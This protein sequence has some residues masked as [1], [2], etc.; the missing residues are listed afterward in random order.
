MRNCLQ[1]G[2]FSGKNPAVASHH[3]GLNAHLPHGPTS[4]G[5]CLFLTPFHT[6]LQSSLLQAIVAF[7]Y[8]WNAPR[9]CCSLLSLPGSWPCVTFS[10][11][12]PPPPQT[13]Q[14]KGQLSPFPFH[15][16]HSITSSE[17]ML[18]TYVLV[19]LSTVSRPS[20]PRLR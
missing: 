9:A 5:L 4:L 8:F 13:T 10:E 16:L 15:F 2:H 19:D 6:A 11:K 14:F 12:H 7:L 17:A 20:T 1:Q 18:C 3:F